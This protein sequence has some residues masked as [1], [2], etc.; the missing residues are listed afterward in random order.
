MSVDFSLPSPQTSSHHDAPHFRRSRR[1]GSSPLRTSVFP[2]PPWCPAEK[3]SA[4]GVSGFPSR[5]PHSRGRRAHHREPNPGLGSTR[6]HQCPAGRVSA[7]SRG[8]A[9]VTLS[10][11]TRRSHGPISTPGPSQESGFKNPH[12]RPNVLAGSPLQFGLRK[13]Y[14][15]QAPGLALDRKMSGA[16]QSMGPGPPPPAHPALLPPTPRGPAP[17]PRADPRSG[18]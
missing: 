9:G 10:D 7:Q 3:A 8:L 12:F 5:R 2:G 15:P 17:G 16:A 18:Q 1:R 14:W 4:C 11:P 13:S 6:C